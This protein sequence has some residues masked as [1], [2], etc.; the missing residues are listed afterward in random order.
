MRA[1]PERRDSDHRKIVTLLCKKKK[2]PQTKAAERH[3]QVF[4]QG[5]IL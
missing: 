3:M 2:W 4:K 1:Q 5:A